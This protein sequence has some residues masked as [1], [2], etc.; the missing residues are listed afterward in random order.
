MMKAGHISGSTLI[1]KFNLRPQ[2]PY[3]CGILLLFSTEL[4]TNIPPWIKK[5]RWPQNGLQMC[6]QVF[7]QIMGSRCRNHGGTWLS[8]VW[9][10]WEAEIWVDCEYGSTSI[11]PYICTTHVDS[12]WW[13][14]I[15]VQPNSPVP[16]KWVWQIKLVRV[17]AI[18]FC[19]CQKVR[20]TNQAYT[21]AVYKLSCWWY[22]Y[23]LCV[24][25]Y[26]SYFDATL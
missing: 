7:Q 16:S 22:T 5:R 4:Q 14:A 18:S 2:S 12:K 11:H 25:S 21:L 6:C 26:G 17:K 19:G 15:S 3:F 13:R 9:T 8:R 10:W 24:G 23:Y 20:V 1:K